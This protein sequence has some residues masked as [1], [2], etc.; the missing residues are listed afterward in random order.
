HR[1]VH[2]EK[3]SFV[4]HLGKDGQHADTFVGCMLAYWGLCSNSG[5]PEIEAA[6]VG[7]FGR[8]VADEDS[9]PPIHR[10]IRHLLQEHRYV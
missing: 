8:P 4:Y 7:A 6:T 9:L 3:G 2:R 1:L 5:P 10:N